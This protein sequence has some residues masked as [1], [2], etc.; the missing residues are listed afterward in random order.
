[1]NPLPSESEIAAPPEPNAGAQELLAYVRRQYDQAVRHKQTAGIVPGLSISEMLTEC[2][3]RRDGVHAPAVLARIRKL[4]LTEFFEP[5]T[6]QKC[7]D[8]L[9]YW[10][11]ATVGFGD[12][13][14]EC[15]PTEHPE[16]PPEILAGIR[17]EAEAALRHNAFAGEREAL[18]QIAAA[19]AARI[20][21][22]ARARAR[23][24]TALI[25]DQ[26]QEINFLALRDAF[27]S[28]LVTYGT[29]FYWGP[30]VKLVRRRVWGTDNAVVTEIPMPVVHVVSPHDV[31][32][33]PWITEVGDYGYVTLRLR[34]Y[35]A[36]LTAFR[37]I[38]G[39]LTDEIDR[40]IA[41]QSAAGAAA[42][43]G[44]RLAAEGKSDFAGPPE[45]VWYY[46]HVPTEILRRYDPAWES[47]EREQY[48]EV[49]FMQDALLCVR[50]SWN[51]LPEPPLHKAV[52]EY[53][54]GSFWGIGI[55]MKMRAAQNKANAVVIPMLENIAWHAGGIT[56]YE[57]HR[58][59]N[60]QDIVN[61]YPGMRIGVKNDPALGPQGGWPAIQHIDFPL[62]VGEL[63]AVLRQAQD[64][65]DEQSG[66]RRYSFGSDRV[67]GA[68]RTRGGLLLLMDASARTLKR[69]MYNGDKAEASLVLALADWNNR[70]GPPNVRGDVKVVTRGITGFLEQEMQLRQLEQMEAQMQAQMGRGGQTNAGTAA[71]PVESEP[72]VPATGGI[73]E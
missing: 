68:G 6:D 1:M 9:A 13:W 58:L 59:L 18:E 10:H 66:V 42:D 51:E 7:R 22:L 44:A 67:A 60:P 3:R 64:E 19:T 20:R 39:W 53:K 47:G 48:V 24:M 50:R 25:K 38:P 21:E 61:C 62:K 56:T 71:A 55:P 14:F 32:P 11:E 73:T 63:L 30:V 2:Q 46:G 5:L 57:F 27:R 45:F 26:L 41:Q 65:A 52:Y 72:N 43:D 36:E 34:V 40:L 8:A 23:A 54:N 15:R 49:G 37:G 31:F 33:A 16:L 28:D 29:A 17:A 4:G 70:F 69:S 35:P 12:D